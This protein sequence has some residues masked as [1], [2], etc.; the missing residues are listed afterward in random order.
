MT[1][2]WYQIN[3]QKSTV[4][5]FASV[6]FIRSHRALDF[7][8]TLLLITL[9]VL[10]VWYWRVHSFHAS[11]AVDIVEI[12]RDLTITKR[13][14]HSDYLSNQFSMPSYRFRL[15]STYTRYTLYAR[16]TKVW[17]MVATI[18]KRQIGRRYRASSIVAERWS[19]RPDV[20]LSV[21]AKG[22][23]R[24]PKIWS[25]VASQIW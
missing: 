17:S 7:D 4:S 2:Q 6:K 21:S 13:H 5:K 11:S 12:S 19:A 8:L 16:G 14:I 10:S 22:V 25:T 9:D 1:W 20:Q 24:L 23:Y 15:Q 18:W 3:T